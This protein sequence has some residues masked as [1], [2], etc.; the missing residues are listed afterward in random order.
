[1]EAAW[2]EGGGTFVNV[3]SCCSLLLLEPALCECE[4]LNTV[5]P[6]LRLNVA[7]SVWS[8]ALT[9]GLTPA[10]VAEVLLEPTLCEREKINTVGPP[11]NVVRSVWSLALTLG[12][13]PAVA[14]AAV[15]EAGVSV[16]PVLSL[17][18]PCRW[19]CILCQH[20]TNFGFKL[21]HASGMKPATVRMVTPRTIPAMA[22]AGKL[23][24]AGVVC[25]GGGDVSVRGVGLGSTVPERGEPCE[26]APH[27]DKGHAESSETPF[28]LTPKLREGEYKVNLVG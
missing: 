11:L 27:A 25:V 9:L 4:K 14:G 12:L 26:E 20:A 5:G 19:L 10:V 28:A 7:C 2:Y 21:T 17:V 6:P 18:L 15:V 1:M 16:D 3:D 13:T 24:L 22:P 8:L 23:V